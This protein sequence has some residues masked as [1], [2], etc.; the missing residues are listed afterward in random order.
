MGRKCKEGEE[1]NSLK[2]VY[3]DAHQSHSTQRD[4]GEEPQQVRI[5]RKD[6]LWERT[7]TLLSMHKNRRDKLSIC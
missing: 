3:K 6:T 7:F 1:D 5:K 2:V 4:H